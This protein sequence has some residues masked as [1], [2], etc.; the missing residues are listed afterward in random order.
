MSLP[1]FNFP[2][3]F[4][5]ALIFVVAAGYIGRAHLWGD[6][7]PT[8]FAAYAERILKTCTAA[9]HRPSCYDRKIPKLMDT[10]SLEDAFAVTRLVQEKDP[11]YFYCHVLGHALSARETRKDPSQWNNVIHRCPS[12]MCSNGCIHGAFQER[13]RAESLAPDKL[14]AILPELENACEAKSGWQPTGLEQA[15]C[16]HALG[17]LAMYVTGADIRA[18]TSLCDTIARKPDGRN[19]LTI[20][21]EGAFMQIFQPLE[22]EDFALVNNIA[23]RTAADA[24]RYCAQFGADT[25]QQSACSRES[26]PLSLKEITTP[27][28][29]VRFCAAGANESLEYRCY[30]A[31]F[32]VLTVQFKFDDAKITAL[33]SGLPQERR[34]QCFA[35]SASRLIE[36]DYKLVDR[37]VDMCATAAKFGV[38][39]ACYDELFFY[40]TFNFHPRSQEALYLCERL[41][42]PWRARCLKQNS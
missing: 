35:N 41:P 32:Y 33:C 38:E 26:W 36:T 24:K 20:C 17:H 11:G 40:S 19:F 3:L 1:R 28:G 18:A 25:E 15:T 5:A 34:G 4:L 30:N 16:Y 12:G 10:L 22:P 27:D 7:S 6:D 9:N 29:L 31:M 37:A 21:Y 2:T 14:T 13:F 39:Q 23:P 42:K 8:R